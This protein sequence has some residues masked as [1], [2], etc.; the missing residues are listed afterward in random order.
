MFS[1]ITFNHE[2]TIWSHFDEE[3]T[4]GMFRLSPTGSSKRKLLTIRIGGDHSLEIRIVSV[5]TVDFSYIG[6]VFINDHYSSRA[7]GAIGVCLAN[8]TMIYSM[9]V[10]IC[11]VS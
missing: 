8:H 10:Y 5:T 1:G 2:T 9:I 3:K 6:L 7:T 11:F 4:A